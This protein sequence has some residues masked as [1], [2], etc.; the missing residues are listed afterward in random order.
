[1]I[2]P[3]VCLLLFLFFFREIFQFQNDEK[4][5]MNKN[6]VPPEIS[7]IILWPQFFCFL[8]VTLR[9]TLSKRSKLPVSEYFLTYVVVQFYPWFRVYSPFFCG[10]VWLC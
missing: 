2:T 6:R 3:F 4:K 7:P 5:K 10:Q 9:V 8:K 1:M